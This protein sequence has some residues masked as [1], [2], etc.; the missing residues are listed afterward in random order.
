MIGE[1][2]RRSSWQLYGPRQEPFEFFYDISKLDAKRNTSCAVRK[3]PNHQCY[4]RI[5]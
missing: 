3:C 1:G 5:T 4:A 2:S